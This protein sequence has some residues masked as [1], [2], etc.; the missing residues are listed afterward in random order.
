MSVTYPE[1]KVL[2]L[3]LHK[4]NPRH[5]PKNDQEQ[6]VHYL[7]ADERVIKL[8]R[9]I[10]ENGL[11][12]LE[13][14]AVFKDPEGNL[15]VAEGN[16]RL[17]ALQ[18][19][20]DPDKAPSKMRSIFQTLSESPN[21][22]DSIPVVE[23]SSYDEA[24]I[25]MSVLHDGEQG[26]IG[27]RTW[28]PE[29]KSRA[30]LRPS[31]DALTVAFLDYAEAEGLLGERSRS[32]YS[33]TTLT[34]YFGNPHVRSSMGIVSGPADPEIEIDISA[35]DFKEIAGAFLD[36]Y[37]SGDVNSRTK[38]GDWKKYAQSVSSSHPVQRI[39]EPTK[40]NTSK[41][42][43]KSRRKKLSGKKPVRM[44]YSNDVAT[45][46]NALGSF[47]LASIYG[48]ITKL[49]LDEHPALITAG[50]WIFLE[51]MT[52]L[53][54]RKEGTSFDSYIGSKI[55][56]WGF[57]RGMKREINNAAKYISDYGN[58]EK[59]SAKYTNIDAS[60]LPLHMEVLEGAIVR[61]LSEAAK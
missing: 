29:Q 46:L 39:P 16:R 1:E 37:L 8:A 54:G 24:R 41:P 42:N 35:E 55:N 28:K 48:S 44:P 31:R 59:H 26:G 5:P 32:E 7:L 56:E 40:L 43:P 9:H 12:P 30:S 60:N 47:K 53:H 3:L 18:L 34:R 4:E 36:D 52:A 15:V 23:F 6:I 25:W 58:A 20:N 11:N 38:S 49:K 21:I 45:A 27:R 50:C 14:L 2:D 10:A 13:L 22:P 57:D 17:C 33:V 19:L 51:C 61:I